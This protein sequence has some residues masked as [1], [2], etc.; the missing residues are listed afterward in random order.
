MGQIY[1]ASD[2]HGDYERYLKLLEAIEFSRRDTLYI[3]GDVIDRHPNGVSILQHIM[4]HGNIQLLMGNH[5]LMCYHT[6]GPE[7]RPGYKQIWMYNGGG[8]TYH[9]LLYTLDKTERKQV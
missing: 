4:A 3:I 6:L 9:D 2:I 8:S 5:E 7:R 1:C